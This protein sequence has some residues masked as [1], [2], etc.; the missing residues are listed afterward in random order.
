M[1]RLAEYRRVS[2]EAAWAVARQ[3]GAC[4]DAGATW[5]K[6]GVRIGMSKQEARAHWQPMV[7]GRGRGR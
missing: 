6:A 3:I 5:G 1:G 4:L 7:S 2:E